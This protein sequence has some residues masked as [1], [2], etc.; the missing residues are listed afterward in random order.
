MEPATQKRDPG[1]LGRTSG[2]IAIG[3]NVAVLVGLVFVAFQIRQN[4]TALRA[5]AYQTWLAT[6]AQLNMAITTGDLSSIIAA[7]HADAKKLTADNNTAYA[8]W[9]YSFMQMAQ[10]TDYLHRQGAI[11]DALWTNEIQRAA[12]HLTIPAVRQW[13]DAG[14][15]TQLTPEFVR[16]IESTRASMTAWVWEANVGFKSLGPTR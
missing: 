10:A 8:M 6:N 9:I 15:K 2:L 14:G 12:G 4:T 13:W 5:T 1:P 3:A 16:L 7:G 11:D